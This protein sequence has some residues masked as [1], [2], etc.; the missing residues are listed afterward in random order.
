MDYDTK[1]RPINTRHVAIVTGP[2]GLRLELGGFPIKPAEVDAEVGR[3]IAARLLD[4]PVNVDVDSGRTLVEQVAAAELMRDP[5]IDPDSIRFDWRSPSDLQV[6]ASAS[7]VATVEVCGVVEPGPDDA[8]L[9]PLDI[10]WPPS[11]D[12]G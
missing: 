9:V 6:T 5:R 4:A 8:G 11:V 10:D 1:Q 7:G 3:T 12:V 2:D